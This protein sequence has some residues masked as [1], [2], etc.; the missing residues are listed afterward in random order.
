L[1][2]SK[3][4]FS[5]ISL[6]SIKEPIELPN[7]F[8]DLAKWNLRPESMVA[9][10]KLVET[11]NDNPRAVIELRAHTDSRGSIAINI[12]LS[13]KRAQSVVNFLIEKGIEPARLRAKGYAATK[14][15]VVDVKIAS[16]LPFLTIG[17]ELT[18]KFIAEL[19]TEEQQEEAYQVNR[20]TEFKVISMDFKPQRK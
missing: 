2:E 19:E 4:F 16:I 3:V 18:P 1:I 7:I 15:K 12:E 10:D 11:L 8:Y 20:R 9:L 17:K 6:P 5:E 14:P 13:Q